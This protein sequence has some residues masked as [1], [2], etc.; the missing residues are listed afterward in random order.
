MRDCLEESKCR[1]EGSFGT[2]GGEL[3]VPV[4]V[5]DFSILKLILEGKLGL[6]Q[7]ATSK[8]PTPAEL[9]KAGEKKFIQMLGGVL[10]YHRVPRVK[11]FAQLIGLMESPYSF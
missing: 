10:K 8:E 11:L 9:R 3:E 6:K 7:R 2:D 4:I 1:S 5:K